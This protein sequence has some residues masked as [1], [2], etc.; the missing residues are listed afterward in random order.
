M[1]RQTPAGSEKWN[2]LKQA[3]EDWVIINLSP[4]E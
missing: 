4:S 1:K 3:L 2:F